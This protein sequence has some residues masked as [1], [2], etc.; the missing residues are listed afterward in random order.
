MSPLAA[1]PVLAALAQAPAQPAPAWTVS[2]ETKDGI[3][4]YRRELADS[5]VE[6]TMGRCLIAAPPDVV[7]AAA[8]R[9]DT[10][11]AL[12]RN[13]EVYRT[14]PGPSEDVWFVYQRVRHALVSPRDLT[15]RYE[16]ER[17]AARGRY[18][19][20]WRTANEQGPPPRDGVIRIE[21]CSGELRVEPAGHGQARVEYRNHTD[22]RGRIPQ[23][24][25]DLVSRREVPELLRALRDAAVRDAAAQSSGR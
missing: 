2:T 18:A 24:A 22:P 19:I 7:F 23:W 6:E 1:L 11:A 15:L 10:Y 13:T 17:D 12:R 5:E 4:V 14:I 3:S 21:D 9:E 16:V 25:V 20:R 8:M